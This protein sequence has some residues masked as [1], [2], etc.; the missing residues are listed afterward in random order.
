MTAD[1]AQQME[2]LTTFIQWITERH[3]H[4]GGC[5]E[6]AIDNDG[7]MYGGYFD[8]DHQKELVEAIRPITRSKIPYGEHPRIG[9]GNVYISTQA[10]H[11]DL[12]A[13]AYNR[14]R[15]AKSRIS[16]KDIIAY[17]LFVV[18]IDPCRKAGICATTDEK[19]AAHAT[20]ER[21]RAWF[22]EHGI[23][24]VQAD[25]GNGYYLIVP[26]VTYNST[27]VPAV[28]ERGHLLLQ[29]LATKFNTDGVEI[30][31]TVGNASRLVRCFGSLN[32]KGDSTPQRPHRWS[33]INLSNVP[34]DI[35]LFTMLQ[36]EL[37]AFAAEQ[38]KIAQESKPV[39][40]QTTTRNTST[41]TR[42]DSIDILERILQAESLSFRRKTKGGREVFEFQTC[43]IHTDD[44][45]HRHE[46]CV[47]VEADGKYGAKC[48]HD[49]KLHWQDFKAAVHWDQHA[50]KAKESLGLVGTMRRSSMTEAGILAALRE[51][52]KRCESPMQDTELQRI[53]KS[54]GKKPAADPGPAT[55]AQCTALIIRVKSDDMKR[56]HWLARNHF[57]LGKLIILGGMPGAGKSLFVIWLITAMQQT[58]GLP[59]V[60]PGG[61]V[62]IERGHAL[63]VSAEDDPFDTIGPRLAAYGV[64]PVTLPI[65]RGTQIIELDG[66]KTVALFDLGSH[67]AALDDLWTQDPEIKLLAIDPVQ[68]YMGQADLN[69][70]A[71]VNHSL[72]VLAEWAARRGVCVILVTHFNKKSDQAALDRLTGS[73]GFSGTVRAA[74][75]VTAD[76]DEKGRCILCC[77]KQQNGPKPPAMAYRIKTTPVEIEGVFEDI[78]IIEFEPERIDADPDELVQRKADRGRLD[79]CLK[80]LSKRLTSGAVLASTIFEEGEQQ[81]FG[82]DLCYQAKAK[83]R[84]HG[85]KGGFQGRTL[86]SLPDEKGSA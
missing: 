72:A 60:P 39:Q 4:C 3:H 29:L 52:N 26:T 45:G 7:Q 23:E 50:E 61:P 49:D 78:P 85:S 21:V 81:G 79:E 16:D 34:P 12:H 58:R 31:T 46:C 54:I 27:T 43:P 13:R 6:I 18:D 47:M 40:R 41:W 65:Y 24:C 74:W 11:P 19:R 53:A 33:A 37:D 64:D 71:A 1:C 57:A 36:G 48:Q 35:D 84:L 9:E 25:S 2:N 82:R 17:T 80:W 62:S 86:W 73:R 55:P 76:P 32:C 15:R 44:D 51:E 69:G 28:A 83:L 70:N 42:Q 22:T 56:V 20:M 5:T 66:T 77:T 67:I 30:D 8:P 10:V 68:T 63:L 38:A 14:I 59:A 75:Q